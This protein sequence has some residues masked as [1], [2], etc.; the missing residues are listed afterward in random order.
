MRRPLDGAVQAQSIGLRSSPPSR[1]LR[2][3]EDDRS[4]RANDPTQRDD[5]DE[6]RQLTQLWR[7]HSQSSRKGW[8]RQEDLI[9]STVAV[10]QGHAKTPIGM[11]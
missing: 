7:E 4:A 2:K 11:M 5:T 6:S 9:V 10:C 1:S 3:V 8:V